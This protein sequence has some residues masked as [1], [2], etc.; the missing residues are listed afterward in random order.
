MYRDTTYKEKMAILKE[1]GPE[2]IEA[3]KKDLKTEHL[4]Q[5]YVFAKKYLGGK[6]ANKISLEDM[7]K[8]YFEAV[9]KEESGEKIAEFIANR[10]MLK[11]SDVYGFFETEL[12]RI[13]PEFTEIKELPN[14]EGDK[15]IEQSS[16]LFG[17][18]KT[19][20]FSVINSVAFSPK[21]FEKLREKALK[22]RQTQLEELSKLQETASFEQLKKE[23]EQK[24]VKLEDKYEQKIAG[25]EKKYVADV[26]ALKK[27]IAT[28][29]RK[30]NG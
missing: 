2:L 29:S 18:P 30:L 5:D 14:A 28:L 10:W 19:Y 16:R 22:E 25:L 12:T 27:Q 9:E 1:W 11:T 21:Q 6:P 4:K 24:L 7:V 26:A 23:F 8:G 15:L 20:L 17:A 3:I 13:N